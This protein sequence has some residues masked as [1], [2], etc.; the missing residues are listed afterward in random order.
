MAE[1]KTAFTPHDVSQITEAYQIDDYTLISRDK[2]YKAYGAICPCCGS[3]FE[4]PHRP[5]KE[6][7]HGVVAQTCPACAQIIAQSEYKGKT[8]GE[9]L[10]KMQQ[11]CAKRDLCFVGRPEFAACM[12]RQL[13]K[14]KEDENGRIN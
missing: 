5:I 7:D 8:F 9:I 2:H 1:Q 6:T 3:F 12:I 13:E 4:S 10:N 11:E 14:W